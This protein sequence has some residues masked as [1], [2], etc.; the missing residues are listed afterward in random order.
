LDSARIRNRATQNWTVTGRE[1]ARHRVLRAVAPY[2][3]LADT[4]DPS[5]PQSTRAVRRALAAFATQSVRCDNATASAEISAAQADLAQTWRDLVRET[6]DQLPRLVDEPCPV[7]WMRRL[8]REA[9]VGPTDRGNECVSRL[10]FSC[11]AAGCTSA[12]RAPDVDLHHGLL[13]E[14]SAVLLP[15]PGD[16]DGMPWHDFVGLWLRSETRGQGHVLPDA[17]GGRCSGT[18]SLELTRSGGQVRSPFVLCMTRPCGIKLRDVRVAVEVTTT[19]PGGD[20]SVW[21]AVLLYTL[22][23]FR[24][25]GAAG[26]SEH[27]VRRTDPALVNAYLSNAQAELPGRDFAV[28]DALSTQFVVALVPRD[29]MDDGTF[30]PRPPMRP[31]STDTTGEE[32]PRK[33]PRLHRLQQQ[34]TEVVLDD[35]DDDPPAFGLNPMLSDDDDVPVYRGR[36]GGGRPARQTIVISDDDDDDLGPA[37]VAAAAAAALDEEPVAKRAKPG[38]FGQSDVRVF[39]Q[40]LRKAIAS[41]PGARV[42]LL[43]DPTEADAVSAAASAPGGAHAVTLGKALSKLRKEGYPSLI[44]GVTALFEI[45]TDMAVMRLDYSVFDAE[46]DDGLA[47]RRQVY[48]TSSAALSRA[49]ARLEALVESVKLPGS[50]VFSSAFVDNDKGE[51]PTALVPPFAGDRRIDACFLL[52]CEAVGMMPTNPDGNVPAAELGDPVRSFV[53]HVC[54]S[55]DLDAAWVRREL[56]RFRETWLGPWLSHGR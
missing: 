33:K 48:V 23:S 44:T 11:D 24:D 51:R 21:T 2:V 1:W 19:A 56:Q 9:H 26:P 52:A 17:T 55:A 10:V 16:R 41:P 47:Y 46:D 40:R 36:P 43:L 7:T 53:H 30:A 35:D 32:Q 8:L 50:P 22:A 39:V 13:L 3:C 14:P 34:V 37:A 38:S 27:L 5:L 4:D 29:Q 6:A 54:S 15:P 31:P 45:G 25:D 42:P 20:Q 12:P 18:W 28:E 49:P